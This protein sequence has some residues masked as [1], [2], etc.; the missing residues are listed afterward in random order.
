MTQHVMVLEPFIYSANCI[1]SCREIYSCCAAVV[2]QERMGKRDGFVKANG[3]LARL[4]SEAKVL[5]AARFGS[6][7]HR[8]GPGEERADWVPTEQL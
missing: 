1:P 2:M 5:V 6:G 8:R 7:Q 4:F 3:W